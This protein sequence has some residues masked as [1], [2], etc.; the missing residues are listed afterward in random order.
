[1]V[2][3][4]KNYNMVI[5][6]KAKLLRYGLLFMVLFQANAS[7]DVK[8]EAPVVVETFEEKVRLDIYECKKWTGIR[9]DCKDHGCGWDAKTKKCWNDATLCDSQTELGEKECTKFNENCFW[10]VHEETK[11]CIEKVTTATAKEAW[12]NDYLNTSSAYVRDLSHTFPTFNV[13][14]EGTRV[15]LNNPPVVNTSVV[16]FPVVDSPIKNNFSIKKDDSIIMEYMNKEKNVYFKSVAGLPAGSGF[17][18]IYKFTWDEFRK[19][20]IPTKSADSPTPT[21]PKLIHTSEDIISTVTIESNPVPFFKLEVG[22]LVLVSTPQE[23]DES[24][25]QN[26]REGKVTAVGT[27]VTIKIKDTSESYTLSPPE[28]QNDPGF[29]YNKDGNSIPPDL[30]YITRMFKSELS[31]DLTSLSEN[32]FKV[33]DSIRIPNNLDEILGEPKDCIVKHIAMMKI[34]LMIRFMV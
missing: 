12:M 33:T 28:N 31:K 15:K 3:Q 13:P 21:L 14:M 7:T 26:C 17:K 19:N 20:L 2:Y 30:Y 4:Q 34:K 6:K 25:L 16:N 8:D 24:K 27:S 32:Q 11:K 10:Y 5:S 1:M 9:T 23:T 22:N 29:V 18:K